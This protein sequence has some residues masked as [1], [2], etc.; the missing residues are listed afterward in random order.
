MSSIQ[1]S[2][3]HDGADEAGV[4]VTERWAVKPG[5]RVTGVQDSQPLE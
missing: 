4:Q 1:A 3:E 2:I 5:L